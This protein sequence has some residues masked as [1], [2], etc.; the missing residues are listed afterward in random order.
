MGIV[1][2]FLIFNCRWWELLVKFSVLVWIF[3]IDFWLGLLLFLLFGCV[4]CRLDWVLLCLVKWGGWY[5]WLFLCIAVFCDRLVCL[6]W[7]CL[8]W[9]LVWYWGNLY[10][11]LCVDGFLGLCW[12]VFFVWWCV[13]CIYW[14]GVCWR[15]VCLACVGGVFFYG[16]CCGCWFGRFVVVVWLVFGFLVGLVFWVLCLVDRLL[17]CCG[18]CWL[19]LIGWCWYW[20]GY[21]VIVCVSFCYGCGSDVL[22]W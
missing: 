20:Y 19:V 12:L 11:N 14:C 10:W 9:E 15:C 18:Y 13:C 8:C 22:W 3:W 2:N 1:C 21:L 7:L 6:V 16:W 4:Y 17:V 5:W